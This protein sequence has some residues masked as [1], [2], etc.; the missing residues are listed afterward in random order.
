MDSLYRLN[1]P[2][3]CIDANLFTKTAGCYSGGSAKGRAV[4]MKK[5]KKAMA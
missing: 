4:P 5:N 2:A 1:F 3:M